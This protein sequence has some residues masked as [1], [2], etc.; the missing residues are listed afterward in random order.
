MTQP[1]QR[2]KQTHAHQ[3]IFLHCKSA[4]AKDV[5]MLRKHAPG[6]I[7]V[8]A[9]TIRIANT[10]MTTTTNHNHQQHH[11]QQKQQQQQ[12]TTTTALHDIQRM[13]TPRP[14]SQNQMICRDIL[15]AWNMIRTP[16]EFKNIQKTPSEAW[17]TD[18]TIK[19]STTKNRNDNVN[20]N[21]THGAQWK[22]LHPQYLK[23]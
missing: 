18:L 12:P 19:T 6:T 10:I 9:Q 11:H 1:T 17:R 23:K 16:L 2:Q 3:L 22:Y 13:R 20:N 21:E 8:R 7:N 14:T 15:Q 4:S 5:D